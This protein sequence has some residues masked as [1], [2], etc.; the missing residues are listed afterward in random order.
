[1][2]KVKAND[3]STIGFSRALIYLR[4]HVALPLTIGEEGSHITHMVDFLVVEAP[5]TYN[6]ILGRRT[7]KKIMGLIS[8]YHLMKFPTLG[9][10]GVIKGDKKSARESYVTS[11]SSANITMTIESL[12]TCDEQKLW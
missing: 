5:S 8:T 1:M 4:G 9:G 6:A 12:D 7:L 2:R 3:L 10:V 11:L